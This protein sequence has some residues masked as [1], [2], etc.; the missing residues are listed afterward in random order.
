[1]TRKMAE[2]YRLDRKSF[3]GQYLGDR[4]IDAKEN[5]LSRKRGLPAHR[6]KSAAA[7][8]CAVV[9]ASATAWAHRLPRAFPQGEAIQ[10]TEARKTFETV[11]ASCHG[12]DGRGGE[13]GPDLV[14]RAE[15]SAKSDADLKEILEKGRTATGMPSFAI[16]GSPMTTQQDLCARLPFLRCCEV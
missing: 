4:K 3:S 8:A 13:R 14:S 1:M 6:I 5:R 9:L 15:V 7:C 16:Y 11:C 10:A 12:L 2:R